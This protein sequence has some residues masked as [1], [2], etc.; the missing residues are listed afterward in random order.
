MSSK[1]LVFIVLD[2]SKHVNSSV[3]EVLF[4]VELFVGEEV[5]QSSLLNELVFSVDSNVFHLFL[6]MSEM[7]HLFF[8]ANISPHGAELLG[9]ITSIDVVEGGELWTKEV[10][11]VSDFDV[12]KVEADQIFVM[13][14]QTSNPFVV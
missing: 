10:S 14:D 3:V 5:N 7:S 1:V 11:E 8:F 12:S 2:R 13:P 9:F 6:G 4:K